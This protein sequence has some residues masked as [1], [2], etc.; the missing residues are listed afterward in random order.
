[1]PPKGRKGTLTP[2]QLKVV[3][4]ALQ[5]YYKTAETPSYREKGAGP[6]DDEQIRNHVLL[7]PKIPSGIPQS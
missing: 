1:M 6:R 7:L 3:K 5:D 2:A 4:V